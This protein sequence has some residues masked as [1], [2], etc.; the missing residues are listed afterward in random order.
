MTQGRLR[1][2]YL[3]EP[4]DGDG[5]ATLDPDESHHLVRVL[6]LREGD[7]IAVFDG[8][9]GEWEA[10]VVEAAS[11]RVIVAVGDP[12]TGT[13]EPPVRVL[14]LQAVARPERIEWVLQKGTEVGVSAFR[15][16][17]CARAEAS[18]PSASRLERY[19]RVVLEA[20][21]QSGRRVLPPVDLG[22][23]GDPPMDGPGIV[24]DPRPALP[25]GEILAGPRHAV[26]ALAIGPEGGLE[27]D[28]LAGLAAKGWLR[29]GLGP[30]VLRTETAGAIAASI[31]LFAWGDL[32]SARMPPT[33]RAG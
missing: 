31:V 4:P 17:G 14:L 2:A 6:R 10:R 21:K 22:A 16:F 1:R 5:R 13:V 20:C 23:V 24:L 26:V 30:R 8:R 25:L 32:G 9:G 18:W 15:L 28:E 33:S 3:K 11:A 12:R 7:A 19:R 27:P 29:A